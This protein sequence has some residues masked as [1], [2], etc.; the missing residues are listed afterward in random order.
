M[1]RLFALVGRRDGRAHWTGCVTRKRGVVGRLRRPRVGAGWARKGAGR[2][3]ALREP[4]RRRWAGKVGLVGLTRGRERSGGVFGRG[5]RSLSASE[6]RC[7]P[8]SGAQARELSP[9]KY[10]DDGAMLK[11]TGAE[12]AKIG[13]QPVRG[14]AEPKCGSVRRLAVLWRNHRRSRSRGPVGYSLPGG[15]LRALG[16]AA[17]VLE[18]TILC[19]RARAIRPRVSGKPA[20]EG[21]RRER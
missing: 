3:A 10:R 20:P 5:C 6:Q 7:S 12:Q 1:P 8:S 18:A 4:C 14:N 9:L 16:A 13:G 11:V 21:D 15:F 19:G 2:G 17:S